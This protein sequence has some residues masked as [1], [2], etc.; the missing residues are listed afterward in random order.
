MTAPL[1][2]AGF[3]DL[4]PFAETWCLATEPQRWARR[5]STTMEDMEA[6]YDACFPR[7][8]DA[9]RHCDRFDLDELPEDATRLLQLLHSLA[10]VSYAVEVWRQPLPVD[11][12]AARIDR[13][14][15]PR[16]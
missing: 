6:F 4:E 12:G 9:I 15:E 10:L 11:T 16:P 8:E 5:Q 13:T 1:L 14:R 3:E 2:P 7:A